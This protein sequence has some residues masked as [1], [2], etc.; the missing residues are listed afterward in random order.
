MVIVMTAGA[1]E[2]ELQAVVQHVE[3][4]AW[5]AFVSRAS[6]HDRRRGRDDD[7]LETVDVRLLPGSARSSGSPRR[8]SWSQREPCPHV[9]RLGPGVPIGPDTFTLI[10]GPCAGRPEQTLA[11][12][13][14]PAA[15]AH[16]AARRRVQAAHLAY[17]SRA[18]R[19]R[20]AHPCRRPAETGC[21]C[22]GDRG[23]ADVDVFSEYAHA[24]GRNP[25]I[26]FRALQAVGAA[27]RPVLLKRGLT[28]T[29]EEWLMAA[30]YVAQRGNLD[31]VLCERGVRSFEPATRNMLDVSAVPMMHALSHLPVVV[32]PSHAAGRR[33][34]VL[35][36]ARAAMAV[37]RRVMV[38]VHPHRSGRSA[39]RPA[40]SG[41]LLARADGGGGD[42]PLA[43]RR[44]G[45][46][47]SDRCWA[48]LAELRLCPARGARLS[49]RGRTPAGSRPNGCVSAPPR[50]AETYRCADRTPAAPRR[51]AASLPRLARRDAAFRQEYG[52][53]GR[54]AAR[55]GPLPLPPGRRRP[56]AGRAAR[57][58]AR[59][60][61]PDGG[62]RAGPSPRRRRRA[63]EV[64]AGSACR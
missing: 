6:P 10:A 22:D 38:D 49:L 24:A 41:E 15:P 52:P 56:P 33:D 26:E 20:P 57:R 55:A 21:R 58:R 1:A 4:A 18:W 28:A 2:A 37:A 19:R 60:P 34:L 36:L 5:A 35:P 14:Q 40:L 31:I 3:A 44:R 43:A 23:R 59:R 30:E 46:V 11:A 9:D 29:Y 50:G 53:A 8:T 48:P 64:P 13:H 47:T 27:G 54:V 45:A 39:R 61:R 51:K 25:Q 63:A 12:A 17:A 7:V 62:G 32:D 16:P 42:P